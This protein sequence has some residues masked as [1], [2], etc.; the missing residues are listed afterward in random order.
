MI[1]YLQFCLKWW[2]IEDATDECDLLS[3]RNPP[4]NVPFVLDNSAIGT[5]LGFLANRRRPPNP[6]RL[7]H[8]SLMG[9]GV[10]NF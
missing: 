6:N 5:H 2:F 8:S 7:S 4:T 1:Y 9:V 3:P 10:Q